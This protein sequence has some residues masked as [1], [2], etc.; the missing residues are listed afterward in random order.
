M[1]SMSPRTL[2]F[3]MA[4]GG[5]GTAQVESLRS[6]V[7][8]IS[9]AH[10]RT[11]RQ[12]LSY[13]FRSSSD[14]MSASA[15]SEITRTWSVHTDSELGRV[16]IHRLQVATGQALATTTLARFGGPLSL[17]NVIHLKKSGKVRYCPICLEN[18]L[19][20][21]E[22]PYGR[23]LWELRGVN[24]CPLHGV[25]LHSSTGCGGVGGKRI[26]LQSRPR[27]IGV[28]PDCGS[29]GRRCATPNL[30]K[31]GS[32]DLAIAHSISKVLALSEEECELV[33]G[34]AVREGIKAVVDCRFEGNTIA[35]ARAAG[36]G[37]GSICT[38]VK[39]HTSVGLAPLVQLSIA[40]GADLSAMLVGRFVS[41]DVHA[42]AAEL[43]NR[44]GRTYLRSSATADEMRQHLSNALECDEAPSFKRTASALGVS[45]EAL[46]AAA[47]VLAK[48]LAAKHRVQREIRSGDA[49]SH[50]LSVYMQARSALLSRGKAVNQKSLQLH[51]GLKAS[52][53]RHG[54]RY[55]AMHDVLSD[56][57]KFEPPS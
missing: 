55:R 36:I 43:K 23:L 57:A 41:A 46:R 39:K 49:Y 30:I 11:T 42:T 25:Q 12:L 34:P 22:I 9:L 33:T 56:P 31:A 10:H 40:G 27:A 4:V 28:C 38:W 1:T 15:P 45:T 44:L 7:E 50:A 20:E 21:Q 3:S 47:P 14:G 52:L 17:S 37:R 24:C 18:D 2:L 8:R 13:L 51:S 26:A 32:V 6:L 48:A 29:V 16:L 19:L 53:G 35:A 54:P 5:L